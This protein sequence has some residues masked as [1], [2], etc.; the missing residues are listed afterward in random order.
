M[1][2]CNGQGV[3][4]AHNLVAADLIE[5]GKLVRL[6]DQ[7]VSMKEHYYLIP[8]SRRHANAASVA[9]NEWLLSQMAEFRET[10]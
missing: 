8:P 9:F 10:V 7:G 4:L 3:A 2:A 1:M 6:F 5:Q